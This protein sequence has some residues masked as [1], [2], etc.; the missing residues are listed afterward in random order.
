MEHCS[1]LLS[2]DIEIIIKI[3]YYKKIVAKIATNIFRI[4]YYK[5]I[6]YILLL[7]QQIELRKLKKI[8]NIKFTHVTKQCPTSSGIVSYFSSSRRNMLL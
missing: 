5:R 4:P 6:K 8:K 3:S 7:N 1:S 2:R